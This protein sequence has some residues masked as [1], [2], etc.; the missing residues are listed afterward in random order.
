MA[1][2]LKDIY[3]KEFLENFSKKVLAAYPDFN[4]ATFIDSIMDDTWE[5]I[6]L[7]ARMRR[8]AEKLG[9]FL[10]G[11]YEHALAILSSIANDCTGFPYL[12]LPEFIVI[13]GRGERHWA[14]SMSALAHFTKQSSAEFAIRPFLIHNPERVMHQMMKW[15]KDPNE[16]VR[17]LSS[18]GCRPRLPWGESLPMFK[19]DPAPV[20]SLLELLKADASLYVRKSVAN[21][22]NDIAKDH[23]D[24]VLKTANR[25]IG[26]HRNTDWIV[27]HGCRTLIRKA[28][29]AALALFGYA[30]EEQLTAYA[31]LTVEPGTLSI[32]DGCDICYKIKLRAGSA[33]R[34]RV[35]Y[36]IDFVKAKGQTS[37]KIFLLSDKT[38][39]GGTTLSAC[40]K[41]SWADLTTRRHYAG[42]H[43]ISLLVNGRE[44]A[45]TELVL[46]PEEKSGL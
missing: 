43:R 2:Q 18:E 19:K 13:Y 1:D 41:H 40:R 29:P 11:P 36:A 32:G 24:L 25:W 15:A 21:N 22:L 17:R 44:V 6:A 23:P 27:R 34:I 30:A 9:R 46:N 20:L 38:V 39:P 10:P 28:D 45:D 26:G 33:V 14:L 35:E 16:H 12:F 3:S 31:S 4:A 5:E 7:K 37:R 8:I 42:N